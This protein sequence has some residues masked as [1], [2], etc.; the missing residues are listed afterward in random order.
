MSASLGDLDPNALTI[1]GDAAGVTPHVTDGAHLRLVGPD[2][3]IDIGPEEDEDDA[4]SDFGENLALKTD[5]MK[6]GMMASQLIADIQADDRSRD[7]WLENRRKGLA[8]LGLEIKDRRDD[9]TLNAGTDA[10]MST[11]VA[12]LLLSEVLKAQATARGELLPPDGPVKVK[13]DSTGGT[14]ARDE[15]ADALE[16]DM[17]TFLT[18]VRTEYYPDTDR[19]LFYCIFGGS[20][21]K[22]VY[23]CP[24]RQS[25][26]SESVDA[27]DLIVNAGAT[28]LRN[29]ARITHVIRMRESMV[30][31]MQMLGAYRD[32]PLG[33]AYEQVNRVAEKE[34]RIEGR[35]PVSQQPQ[36]Q[37]RT[38][39][40]CLCEYD[41]GD[42]P[43]GLPLPYRVTIDKTS[44]QILEI[45]RN[46]REG[47]PLYKARQMYVRYPYIDAIGIYGIGLLHLLGNTS[48]ALTG[49]ERMLLDAGMFSCF[50]GYLYADSVSR[51]DTNEMR[52]PPGGGVRVNTGA[53]SMRDVVMPLP[54]KEPSSVLLAFTEALAKDAAAMAGSAEIPVGEGHAQMPVGT[55][56]AMLEQATK[57]M[58][59]VHKRLHAAQ[60]EE[61]QLLADLLREDPEAFWRQPR[62][63]I[64]EWDKE[65]FLR[66]LDAFE[67]GPVADP[68][69]PTRTHRL[70]KAQ[71]LKM[72]QQANPELYDAKAIDKHLLRMLGFSNP[73]EFFNDAPAGPN[74][75]AEMAQAKIAESH[76]KIQEGQERVKQQAQA[77]Q[78]KLVEARIRAQTQATDTA[79]K[80]RME[81]EKLAFE[82]QKLGLE[83]MTEGL[84]GADDSA[85]KHADRAL[86]GLQMPQPGLEPPEDQDNEP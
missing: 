70:L 78:L 56:L 2:V 42:G 84:K 16:K 51:Q 77:Q 50:P 46:W 41:L 25:P 3:A 62:R 81:A 24:I 79:A 73:Q 11:V 35:D 23:H 14:A 45:R 48:K 37:N 67:L 59:A 40:E 71:A 43:D 69:D 28:D 72:L 22:K 38:I 57:P 10:N 36:D 33:D 21:F 44:Q 9:N 7:E 53:Q 27:A 66:A 32:I 55:M 20:G 19:M 34:A 29:A 26:V 80:A 6:I 58:S 54:Y 15:L 17:N 83:G 1:A 12:P 64:Y 86:A 5:D 61:F 13:D 82:R 65:T 39:Y 8:L 75:M 60:A 49:A 30:K 85:H 4:A 76:A 68:N 52:V 74:P 31:R 63:G 47:D 18:Q